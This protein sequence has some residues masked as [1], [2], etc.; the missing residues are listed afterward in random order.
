M[1]SKVIARTLVTATAAIAVGAGSLAT[2]G[3]AVA[4]PSEKQTVAT[5]E[6]APLAVVNLGLTINQAK[7]VQSY[8][9]VYYG[10]TG[11]VDGQLGTQSWK[12]MQRMLRSYGYSGAIDGIVGGG[13]IQSLQRLLRTAGYDGPIDGLAGPG[14]QAAFKTWAINLY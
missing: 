13:T 4:A 7:N 12:A 11:A 3:T 10:Y 8:L 9:K 5:A 2:A 6:V 14:T 1:R